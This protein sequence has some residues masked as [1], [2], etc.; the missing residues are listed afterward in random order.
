MRKGGEQM[1]SISPIYILV[2]IL[3]CHNVSQDAPRNDDDDDD[4]DTKTWK[5]NENH[6]FT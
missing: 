1:K 5:V 4:N 6:K 2:A 3:S